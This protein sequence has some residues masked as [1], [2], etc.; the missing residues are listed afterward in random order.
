MCEKEPILINR[1]G[2]NCTLTYKKWM[3]T[4][5]HSQSDPG[6]WERIWQIGDTTHITLRNQKMGEAIP[7]IHVGFG[8]NI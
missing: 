6:R 7:T 2:Q 3:L 8:Q 5:T 4:Q 1:N